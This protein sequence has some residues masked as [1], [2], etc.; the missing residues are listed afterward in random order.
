[1]KNSKK[2]KVQIT[3]KKVKG[4]NGYELYRSTKKNG[5]YVKIKTIK[6]PNTVKFT[7]SKLKKK[8]QYYYK[9]R[10]YKILNGRKYYSTFTG[11]RGV[12]IRK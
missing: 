11:K 2:R 5:K 3:W 1:M 7:D 6:K 9:I 8:K 12:K 4:A 10:A